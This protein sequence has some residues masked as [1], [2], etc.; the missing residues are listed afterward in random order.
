MQVGLGDVGGG[1]GVGDGFNGL[2]R[3]ADGHM[4]YGLKARHY[5]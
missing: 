1:V 3:V 4:L 2:G 5:V